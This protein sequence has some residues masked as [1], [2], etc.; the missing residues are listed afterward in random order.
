V[1]Q[2][3]SAFEQQ[4]REPTKVDLSTREPKPVTTLSKAHAAKVLRK[5]SIAKT[6]RRSPVGDVLARSPIWRKLGTENVIEATVEEG[7][8]LQ[9]YFDTNEGRLIHKWAHYFD[10][11]HHHFQAFRN[12]P[13]TIVEFG[14]SH[15]GSLQ[16]WKHYFGEQARII[17]VDINPKCAT[18][19]E[20]QI[21]VV[22]GD[23]E[24]REFLRSLAASVGEVD[25]LIEDGGHTMNQQIATFEELW[26]IVVDGGVF[27]MEDLHTSYWPEYGGGL[28]RD[29]TFIEY[30]KNLI[31]QQHAWHAREDTSFK[32]DGYTKTIRAMHVYDS[33]IVFD[34]A[35][36][37]KPTHRKTGTPSL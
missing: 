20:P 15:G 30:A 31:D 29:G 9:D 2:S 18:L 26:P 36:V 13:V 35:P 6:V 22:I 27:L 17:G 1:L 23:Q 28:R 32:V 4:Y 16:M 12:R 14:I 34:K 8:P 33:V 19:A 5:S 37:P 11:Y 25:V 10:I 24:N 21:E 7:N 3:P